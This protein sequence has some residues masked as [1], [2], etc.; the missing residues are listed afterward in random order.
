MDPLTNIS[1]ANAKSILL[2]LCADDSQLTRRA[3]NLLRKIDTLQQREMTASNQS[4]KKR[5][6]SS[7]IRICG[8]CQDSFYEEENNDKACRYHSGE[9]EVDYESDVW[10]DHDENCHGEINTDSNRIEFPEGFIWDCCDKLGYRSG[11]TRGRHDANGSRGIYGTEPGTVI[12]ERELSS[13]SESDSSENDD[14]E[15]E[16]ESSE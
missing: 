4:G 15:E 16:D 2:A 3:E 10:A 5:K 7:T 11:C 13:E 1:E 8:Q 9:L 6:A 14:A 12:L